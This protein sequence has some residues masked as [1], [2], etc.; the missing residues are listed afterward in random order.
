MR[1]L[2][3]VI[4]TKGPAWDHTK[5]LRSQTQWTEHAEF[6]DRLAE[7]GFII[8]G[9]PLGDSGDVLLVIDAATEEEIRS[10]LSGDP[11]SPSGMLEI[12]SIRPWNILLESPKRPGS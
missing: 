7:S 6:M 5:P 9:G 12:K 3:A 11:W 2:F 1:T 8:L 4:R 10:R